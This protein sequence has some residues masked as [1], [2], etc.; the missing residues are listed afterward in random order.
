MIFKMTITTTTRKEDGSII[1]IGQDPINEKLKTYPN[2]NGYRIDGKA[3]TVF[4]EDK[5]PETA[6]TASEI[7]PKK[8][9]LGKDEF[10][11]HVR[12][13]KRH[14]VHTLFDQVEEAEV[15]CLYSEAIS[16]LQGKFRGLDGKPLV[17]ANVSGGNELITTGTIG[18]IVE[19]MVTKELGWFTNT[20]V[21]L[22][23]IRADV[24][25][26]NTNFL[27]PGPYFGGAMPNDMIGYTRRAFIMPAGQLAFNDAA[28]IK[29]T[30]QDKSYI[31]DYVAKYSAL[32]KEK[33][34]YDLPVGMIPWTQLKADTKCFAISCMLDYAEGKFL[35]G[36]DT[37]VIGYGNDGS[38]TH[39][40]C[41]TFT[42]ISIGGSSGSWIYAVVDGKPYLVAYLF[43]GSSSQ[44][45]GHEIQNALESMEVRPLLQGAEPVQGTIEVSTTPVSG[46]V[47][48]NGESK[49]K[50]P[51]SCPL[52]AGTYTISFGEV[53]GYKKPAD[54][55]TT[56]VDGGLAIVVGIY[57]PI[58]VPEDK[59]FTF[60]GMILGIFPF[61][62][63]GNLNK[64]LKKTLIK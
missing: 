38:V 48:I 31:A 47:F 16:N 19:D 29:S 42:P 4:V 61:K 43:A 5:I 45:I 37:Y 3:I 40:N 36:G 18:G 23:S 24:G 33:T 28:F 11:I 41:L 2:Y 52:K 13:N 26:Q 57:T 8:L 20:H 9:S 51:L 59:E 22:P 53:T 64:A 15:G 7:L 25:T 60:S 58:D 30:K 39:S 49:G 12:E 21:A 1:Q 35:S 50:A 56:I 34:G 14:R 46:E 6:L 63:S 27:Q 10:V 55:T 32:M 62:G 44:T 54:R 17:P